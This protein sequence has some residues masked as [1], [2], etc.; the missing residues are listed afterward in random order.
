MPQPTRPIMPTI[1]PIIIDR[2]VFP[3]I[4]PIHKLMP[5]PKMSENTIPKVNVNISYKFSK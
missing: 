2:V 3:P 4:A 1:M 5:V